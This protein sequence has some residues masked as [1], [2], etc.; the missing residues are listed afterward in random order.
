MSH[1]VVSD[2]H[3]ED[4]RW[5]A[6]LE[7]I[8]FSAQDTLYILGD[9]VDRGPHGVEI[10]QE[11]MR[12]PNMKMLLGNHEFM[13]LRYFAPDAPE[14]HIQHWNRNG[15]TPTLEGFSRLTKP[16]REQVLEFLRSLPTHFEL[17]VGEQKFYL[18]HGLPADT[19]YDEVWHRPYKDPIPP[20]TDCQIIVGHTPVS[21]F[22][23]TD[24]QAYSRT[25]EEERAYVQQMCARGE[26]LTIFHHPQ[27]I[28]ID[29]C[30]GYDFPNRQLAC[31]RL[32]DMQEFY[33]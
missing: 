27:Y 33:V 17:T 22:V 25:D 2:V 4:D 16:E 23:H 6:M 26:K 1:Y 13:C 20:M 28:D 32:E 31:I 29:C 21:C 15:N 14:K 3:G 18:V 24:T 5:K 19:V 9:V 11:I 10:L 12:T 30:C 7:K 8:H